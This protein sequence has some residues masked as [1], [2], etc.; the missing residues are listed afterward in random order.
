MRKFQVITFLMSLLL[1]TY[2]PAG[3]QEF[4]WND[5]MPRTLSEIIRQ[6]VL[7]QKDSLKDVKT[8]DQIIIDAD[9]LPSV[10][11]VTYTRKTKP[12]S[13]DRKNY[14]KLWLE[15]FN[16]DKDLNNIYDVEMLVVEDSNQYWRWFRNN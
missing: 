9:P 16:R 7:V 4:P 6:N 8:R 15:S 11:R 2:S 13:K 12:I 5:F 10:I 1:L 3:A 14:L